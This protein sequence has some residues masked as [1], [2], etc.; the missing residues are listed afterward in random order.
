MVSSSDP[1]ADSAVMEGGAIKFMLGTAGLARLTQSVFRG[2]RAKTG[3]A[4]AFTGTG[5]AEIR[6]C[7]FDSNIAFA[8]GVAAFEQLTLQLDKEQLETPIK[9]TF[10][11][12][13]AGG[14]GGLVWCRP[15]PRARPALL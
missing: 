14:G 3:G 15:W 4:V 11:S 6:Q 1:N 7:V 2:N 10:T 8:S 13:H 5:R 9:L 12:A